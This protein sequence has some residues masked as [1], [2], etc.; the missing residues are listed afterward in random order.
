METNK[1]KTKNKNTNL[2][3]DMPIIK[4]KWSK[5]NKRQN[6]AEWIKKHNPTICYLQETQ[7]Q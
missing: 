5:Y 3:P 2:S 6:L 1:Q 4:Y 7:I